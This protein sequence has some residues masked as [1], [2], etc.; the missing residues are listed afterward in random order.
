MSKKNKR[1][2]LYFKGKS[3]RKL[4]KRMQS[5]QNKHKKRFL[6]ASIQ[7]DGEVFCCIALTNPTEVVITSEDGKRHAL[8]SNYEG[9]QYLEVYCHNA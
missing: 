9:R 6:S 3:M 5:W 2:I 1:N 8:L 4:Y 7:K